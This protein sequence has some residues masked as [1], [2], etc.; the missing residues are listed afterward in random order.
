ML[1]VLH[2]SVILFLIVS[3]IIFFG[4][5]SLKS[6]L[7][8]GIYTDEEKV[9]KPFI[10][11]PAVTICARNPNKSLTGWKDDVV[12]GS[13][14][15]DN[16]NAGMNA[17]YI[18]Q[19]CGA[20]ASSKLDNCI[21]RKSFKLSETVQSCRLGIHSEAENLIDSEFWTS[22]MTVSEH[23]MCY[24]I[25]YPKKVGTD[26]FKEVLTFLF[27]KDLH[28]KVLIHDS[29]FFLLTANPSVIPQIML[30][31]NGEDTK[32][33]MYF[34][35]ATK[36]FLMNRK[37]QP[38]VEDK[39]YSFTKCIKESLSKKVGCR[40]EWNLMENSSLPICTSMKDI[41]M[42]ENHYFSLTMLQQSAVVKYTGCH[43]PCTYTEYST[44]G[45]PYSRGVSPGLGKEKELYIKT[46][47]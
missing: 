19:E 20:V 1:K 3:F 39:S 21:K 46:I 35:K 2:Y 17:N 5:P 18:A 45:E 44:V 12:D 7:R 37:E 13:T 28:Y 9:S 34:L 42:M 6:F 32:T 15:E 8:R 16:S 41:M 29:N 30:E 4:V 10:P 40:L 22:D 14:N 43:I 36:R 27:D 24:T 38:C 23:G 11:L 25:N 26:P 31:L 33:Q 47:Y